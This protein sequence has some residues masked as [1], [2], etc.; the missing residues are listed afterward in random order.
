M[1]L[2][3]VLKMNRQLC[4]FESKVCFFYFLIN[5]IEKMK[6]K[7]QGQSSYAALGLPL[8]CKL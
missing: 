6:A 4:K 8:L 2:T 3:V 1:K 5:V 7:S